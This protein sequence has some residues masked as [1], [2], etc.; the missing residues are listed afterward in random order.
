MIGSVGGTRE[1]LLKIYGLMLE[2]LGPQGWWPAQTA[3]ECAVG[4]ILTQNT[5]WTNVEKAVGNLKAAGA[6]SVKA[7]DRMP[8]SR[9]ARLIRPSGY[10]N[11]KARRLKIFARFVTEHHGGDIGAFLSGETG[12]LRQ[13]LLSIEGI[14]PETADSIAL[15][16]AE[17]PLFVVDAYTKRITT[18]H[19]LT[20]GKATYDEVQ[21][22]FAENLP[23]SA[24]MFNEYHALI[25]RTAKEFCHKNAPDCAN[26]PLETDL[27][28]GL[29]NGSVG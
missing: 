4:A 11:Q 15:Y 19:G 29:K 14:G 8:L 17:K 6:L 20:D 7:I 26:C 28:A 24:A 27:P 9:L 23:Q 16:A 3:F 22:L 21:G 5:A 1:R 12:R 18:R 2:R 10:F 13:T 25:V